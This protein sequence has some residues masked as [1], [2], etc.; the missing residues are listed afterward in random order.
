MSAGTF[1]SSRYQTNAGSIVP[2]S[3]Q[4]ETLTL[5]I[6][7]VAN[8]AP[9]TALTPDFP[10]AKVS[11]GRRSIGINARLV[12]FVITGATTPPGYKVNGILTLPIL[13]PTV[14]SPLRS[15]NVGTYTLNAT[16]YPIRVVGRTAEAIR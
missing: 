12:R 6:E 2:I 11:G 7:G 1:T 8:V 15:G 14:F 10:S 9:T 16:D 3:I 5:T 13:L 4:P